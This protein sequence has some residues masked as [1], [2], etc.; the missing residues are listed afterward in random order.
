M[1]ARRAAAV[2]LLVGALCALCAAETGMCGAAGVGGD[3]RLMN[4]GR[5]VSREPLVYVFDDF[6]SEEEA[7]HLIEM[8]KLRG[9]EK[10]EVGTGSSRKRDTRIR[11]S[12]LTFLNTVDTM[13]DAGVM[14]IER[15]I[16][17]ATGWP[18]QYG[19]ALQVQRYLPGERYEF[20]ADVL[21]QPDSYPQQHRVCDRAATF[22]MYL[23]DVEEGGATCFP[24]SVPEVSPEAAREEVTTRTYK[25]A[26]VCETCALAVAPKRG[27]AVLFFPTDANRDINWF[28]YHAG[29]P[30]KQGVKWVSQKWIE[31]CIISMRF[32]P[33]IR[34][35]WTVRPDSAADRIV[36]DVSAS[37][38]NAVVH[39]DGAGARV[40]TGMWAGTNWDRTFLLGS[41]LAW[42]EASQLNLPDL[43]R[44]GQLTVGC[45]FK[46][47]QRLPQGGNKGAALLVVDVG[48]KVKLAVSANMRVSFSLGRKAVEAS[49]TISAGKWY[50]AAAVVHGSFAESA[51]KPK[52]LSWSFKLHGFVLTDRSFNGLPHHTRVAANL[53][54]SKA[55]SK[56]KLGQ[57]KLRA[58]KDSP[59][60]LSVQHVFLLD[61]ALTKLETAAYAKESYA[62]YQ[63]RG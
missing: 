14:N 29:C 23:R 28:A 10:S 52:Q 16:A 37:G 40:V 2:L 58:G 30:V 54:G 46:L 31:S 41:G 26:E 44:S 34:L 33:N 1:P 4:G 21:F 63:E 48:A 47:E 8:G 27:R 24:L 61:R 7:E 32:D 57:P 42:L 19:E 59:V 9:M 60:P 50:W 43:R 62:Q 3:S 36:A 18:V 17:N 15:R 53:A 20:H 49:Q 35:H 22:L 51:S 45:W 12:S 55:V 6:L 56:A 38:N 11:S 5:V 13:L 25:A 39:S